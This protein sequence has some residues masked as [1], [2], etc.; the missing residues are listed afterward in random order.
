MTSQQQK[1]DSSRIIENSIRHKIS[2]DYDII[3]KIGVGS[4]GVVKKAKHKETG[5]VVA[6]KSCRK[7]KCAKEDIQNEVEILRKVSGHPHIC[8]LIDC[9]ESKNRVNFV[10]DLIDGEEL[11]ER[12][13]EIEHYSEKDASYLM[14]QICIMV[15]YLH[16]KNIVHRDLKPENLLFSHKKSNELKLIDFGVATFIKDNELISSGIVGSRTYM[17]PEIQ[18]YKPY[19]KACDMFSLGVIMYI[20]LCGYPPFD[21][22]EGITEL[23][24]P[25]PDWDDISQEA[26]D[27]ILNLLSPE[28]SFRYTASELKELKWIKGDDVSNVELKRTIQSLSEFNTLI[29]VKSSLP[30]RANQL[31]IFSAFGVMKSDFDKKEDHYEGLESKL[32]KHVEKTIEDFRNLTSIMKEITLKCKNEKKNKKLLKLM[33]EMKSLTKQFTDISE[34]FLSNM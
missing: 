7:D 6:I 28:P 26:K 2:R 25:S 22:E 8:N 20:L 29:K 18:N 3:E 31:S 13:L 12:I 23:D 19:G 32:N 1:N 10:M 17:A 33:G 27:I 15:E 5:K 34:D 24:F 16:S 30:L 9:Y 4:F 14:K 21:Y 11:F